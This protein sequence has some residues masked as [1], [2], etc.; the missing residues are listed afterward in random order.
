MKKTIIGTM[1]GVL[2]F[3]SLPVS[4]QHREGHWEGREIHRFAKHDLKIWRQ[5]NWFHGR[6]DGR[7]GWWWISAWVWYFY[8]A[9]VYPYPD[10]YTPPVTVI[11]QQAPVIMPQMNAPAQP[12]SSGY[13]D[14]YAPPGTIT[15]QQPAVIAPQTNAPAQSPSQLWY[16]C[17]S[18]KGYFPYV[19]SCPEAWRPVP[20]QSP[21]IML[22]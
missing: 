21:Q 11:Y 1:V 16:Y 15:M 2:S 6:H 13:P 18:A 19:S 10:P 8:P 4:A 7:F 3:I 9:P 17:D 5:G 22:K 20:A 12:Q 14:P